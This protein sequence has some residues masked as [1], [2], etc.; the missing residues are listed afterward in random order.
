MGPNSRIR[1]GEIQCG[2]PLN[3]SLG[4]NGG[5]VS[6]LKTSEKAEV[7]FVITPALLQSQLA[8]FD[9]GNV[10]ALASP[11]DAVDFLHC[12]HQFISMLL[13]DFNLAGGA[14]LSCFPE[15]VM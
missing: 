13:A 9:E 14:E 8:S 6:E 11:E 2:L 1:T 5:I 4:D 12:S 7:T 15:G 3:H 10:A